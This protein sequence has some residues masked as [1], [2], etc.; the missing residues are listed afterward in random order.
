MVGHV[1]IL[2]EVTAVIVKQDI[3]ATTVKQV[4]TTEEVYLFQSNYGH[5]NINVL[6]E[7]PITVFQGTSCQ[8]KWQILY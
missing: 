3:L 6:L 2:L 7:I 1:W 5:V 4:I 8:L